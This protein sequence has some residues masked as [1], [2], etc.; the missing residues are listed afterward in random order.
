MNECTVEGTMDLSVVVRG[1]LQRTSCL[2]PSFILFY[3]VRDF[4]WAKGRVPKERKRERRRRTE[5]EEEEGGGR[6][7]SSQSALCKQASSRSGQVAEGWWEEVRGWG[8][9]S[10][11]ASGAVSRADN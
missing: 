10:P 4:N 6:E 9:G 1:E 8:G 5:E 2:C 3:R 7:G 11:W